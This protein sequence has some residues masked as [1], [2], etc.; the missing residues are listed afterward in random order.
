MFVTGFILSYFDTKI[1]AQRS[2]W[3]LKMLSIK[4]CFFVSALV[5]GG[6]TL[7]CR[8]LITLLRNRARLSTAGVA[9]SSWPLTAA[10]CFA[11]SPLAVRNSGGAAVLVYVLCSASLLP[12]CIRS[13]LF[14]PRAADRPF[15]ACFHN[16]TLL[17]FGIPSV[18]RLLR[19]I[20]AVEKDF[21]PS[22]GFWEKMS[23]RRGKKWKKD[24]GRLDFRRGSQY[25]KAIGFNG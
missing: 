25:D 21:Q 19:I 13:R 10:A 11:I 14:H 2:N 6:S 4:F 17:L 15:A 9:R 24:G 7:C 18:G 22:G 12:L 23:A 1:Y 3:N 8:P 20:P 16:T 5:R